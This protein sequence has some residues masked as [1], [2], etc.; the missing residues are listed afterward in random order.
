MK[1]LMSRFG[2]A[3]C[4]TVVVG[5]LLNGACTV[6]PEYNIGYCD[7]SAYF[8]REQCPE[9]ADAG[10]DATIS[11]MD[12]TTQS[13]APN[14][15]NEI[16]DF[17]PGTWPHCDGVCVPEPSD[18]S[19]GAWPSEPLLVWMGPLAEM[20]AECPPETPFMKWKRYGD[21]VAPPASCEACACES[22]G[23]CHGLPASIEIHNGACNAGNVESRPFDGPANWD[24]SCSTTNAMAAGTL[25]NGVPCAQSVS[26]SA[27][28][29]PAKEACTPTIEKPSATTEYHWNEGALACAATEL[30]GLCET[31]PEH[32][33][34][35]L[36]EPW[37]HCVAL[38]GIHDECPGNYDLGP[39]VYY[40]DPPI[41]D[42]GCSDCAC[43]APS[44]IC[45]GSLRVYSDTNC[46]NQFLQ[47]PLSS[48]DPNCG[49]V[50]PAGRSLGSKAIT[51]LMYFPGICAVGG[52]EPIGA[53]IPNSMGMTEST[54]PVTFCCRS[55]VEPKPPGIPS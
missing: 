2:V 28:P 16:P 39:F 18:T 14:V 22:S 5:I 33:V 41:D 34:E 42:R 45:V 55:R 10:A 4:L 3:S 38:E 44:G 6:S 35:T 21:L 25:C 36:P 13:D 43:G 27:L 9:D 17:L 19:A 32:C 52:G 26:A 29:G 54:T 47:I 51:D 20:P 37:L 11:E 8:L 12:A 7:S 50:T 46:G 1:K 40:A 15:A 49:G 31:A 48:I 53:A 30:D 24:G 23:E